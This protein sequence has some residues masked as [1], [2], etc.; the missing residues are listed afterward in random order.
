[1]YRTGYHTGGSVAFAAR[2][3]NLLIFVVA[4]YLFG[5]SRQG[6]EKEP[7]EILYD[8]IS[9]MVTKHRTEGDIHVQV[10]FRPFS[11]EIARLY[12]DAER[13]GWD[14]DQLRDKLRR[15]VEGFEGA[16]Y[17]AADGTDI[18]NL[19]YQYLVYVNPSFDAMNPMHRDHFR[20]FKEHHVE[21]VVGKVYDITQDVLRNKYDDRW[22]YVQYSRLVFSIQLENR[23]AVP[24]PISEIGSRTFLTDEE[25]NRYRP[26]G[27][28]GPYPYSFDHPRGDL[29][30]ASDGYR[31]FFPN[32]KT[33]GTP[34][35]TEGTG[36]IRLAIEDLG[37]VKE[38]TFEWNL[39][40]V[41][42]K[43]PRHVSSHTTRAVPPSE[44]E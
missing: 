38:R 1:M 21:Q 37:G 10:T 32:R 25:G 30:E 6:S 27:M 24:P 3:R 22:G 26:S 44:P 18:N 39:P 29:L 11:F 19:F 4:M 35:I 7:M 43:I 17:P 23:G 13:Y 28:S 9:A 31:V 34:I 42:P 36:I 20:N 15:H 12:R 14:R 41:Y 40:F 8:R 5:C 33:D 2:K 16:D